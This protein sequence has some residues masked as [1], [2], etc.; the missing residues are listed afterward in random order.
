MYM[1]ICTYVCV[2]EYPI[3]CF[4]ICLVYL[5]GNFALCFLHANITF[6]GVG[7]QIL[8]TLCIYP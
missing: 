6:T 2:E 3:E 7:K 4:A 1:Y 5:N 8:G